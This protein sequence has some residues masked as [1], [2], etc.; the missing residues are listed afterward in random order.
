MI[1]TRIGPD[2]RMAVVG[3]PAYFARRCPA[4]QTPRD[5]TDHSLQ[6]PAPAHQRRAV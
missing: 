1:A 5:L 3:S 4:P 2:M 6:Q